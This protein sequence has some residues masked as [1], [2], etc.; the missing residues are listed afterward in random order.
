MYWNELEVEGSGFPP[1]ACTNK[2]YL[3]S[4]MGKRRLPAGN[5]RRIRAEPRKTRRGCHLV[6]SNGWPLNLVYI[7]TAPAS[8]YTIHGLSLQRQESKQTPG[9]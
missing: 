6:R 7:A 2:K 1:T 9:Q 8:P 4:A 3:A 5:G